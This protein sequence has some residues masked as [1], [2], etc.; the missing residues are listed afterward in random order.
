M[1]KN[2]PNPGAWP[3]SVASP[4]PA[5]RALVHPRTQELASIAGRAPAAVTQS[6]Y[7]QAQ[8]ELT[9]GSDLDRQNTICRGVLAFG[10]VRGVWPKPE[11]PGEPPGVG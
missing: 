3:V 1:A 11:S 7:E 10:S 4:G 9:G 5:T 2:Y 8:R 6:D